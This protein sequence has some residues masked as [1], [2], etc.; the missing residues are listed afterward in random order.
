M[1]TDTPAPRLLL[2]PKAWKRFAEGAPWAFSNEVQMDNAAKKLAPGTIARLCRPEGE[3]VALVHFNPHSLIAARE[4]TRESAALEAGALPE[5]WL[6]ERLARAGALRERLFERPF[7]RLAHAEGDRLPGLVVDR[8]DDLFV[9]QANTAGMDR[10]LPQID[11]LL[12]ERFGAAAILHR[13]DSATRGL[14]GLKQTVE[15]AHGAIEGPVLV[16][17]NGCRLVADP[18]GGQKTGWFFDHRDNRAFAA[19]MAKGATMLDLYGYA[20]GFAIPAAK[21]GADHVI[22][23]DRSADAL[24]LAARAAE[25]NGVGD[26][27]RPEKADVFDFLEMQ[28]AADQRFDLVIADP[29]AFAKNRK[30]VKQGLK[31]Y[32]KLARLAAAVTAE[33][34]TLMLASCSHLVDEAA[35]REA[36]R[37]GLK[38]AGRPARLIRSA[39]AG[40][41]HPLHPD[42]AESGYLKALFFALD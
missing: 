9:V 35:F 29:P 41:D 30:S 40:P 20:G 11:A 5:D 10:M 21:A 27:V 28:A 16:E 26:R 39:G 31:A 22:T 24:M 13:N 42:L 14:E 32:A 12:R 33:G 3:P 15:V 36:C 34:G 7:Y 23:V 25:A 4:L 37:H 1:M 19:R 18:I 17:E 38:E 8:F 2:Q 6:A